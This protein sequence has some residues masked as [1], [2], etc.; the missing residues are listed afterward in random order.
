MRR[1][2]LR[3]I[4]PTNCRHHGTKTLLGSLI[5]LF[6]CTCALVIPRGQLQAQL[7][8]RDSGILSKQDTEAVPSEITAAKTKIEFESDVEPILTEHCFTCHSHQARVTEGGLT[9]DSKIGWNTGGQSGPAIQ[10][11]KPDKSLFG[12][13]DPLC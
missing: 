11:G 7:P 8:N 2:I 6:C 4:V 1:S 3:F 9:L 13:S 5:F 10:P 12:P